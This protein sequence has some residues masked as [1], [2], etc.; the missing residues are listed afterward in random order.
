MKTIDLNHYQNIVFPYTL[1]WIFVFTLI[2]LL[3]RPPSVHTWGAEAYNFDLQE[4]I[5]NKALWIIYL[6]LYKFQLQAEIDVFHHLQI[7]KIKP[8]YYFE[9][10]RP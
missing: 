7:L 2:F 8:V 1:T 6:E 9:W 5:E 10:R 4:I 3:A